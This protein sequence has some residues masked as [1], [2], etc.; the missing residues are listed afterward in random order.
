MAYV[1]PIRNLS[2]TDQK[3]NN[4]DL[5]EG[6]ALITNSIINMIMGTINNS[7]LRSDMNFVMKLA[8]KK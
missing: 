8:N 6:F 5:E 7:F 1:A 3:I 4:P 2:I